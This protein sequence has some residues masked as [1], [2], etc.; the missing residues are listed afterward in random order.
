MKA[1]KWVIAVLFIVGSLTCLTISVFG[2]QDESDEWWNGINIEA[3]SSGEYNSVF[4]RCDGIG[5]VPCPYGNVK[6]IQVT[7]F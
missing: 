2:Q 5:T 6:V 4:W 7:Y 3:L 1:K